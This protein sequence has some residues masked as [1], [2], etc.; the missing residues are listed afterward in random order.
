ME[1]AKLAQDAEVEEMWLTHYS[2]SLV[3]P[4]DYMDDVRKV[5]P[6][7]YAWKRRKDNG[8]GFD[9]RVDNKEKNKMEKR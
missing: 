9:G 1:A 3:R 5:F 4:E 6:N 2:P 8:T 7:A